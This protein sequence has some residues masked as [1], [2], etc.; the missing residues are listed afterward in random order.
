M[1]NLRSDGL[2]PINKVTGKA[3]R[4]NVNKMDIALSRA[5]EKPFRLDGMKAVRRSE[6]E[7]H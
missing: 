3:E 6:K 1:E 5:N 4:L 7:S 2:V